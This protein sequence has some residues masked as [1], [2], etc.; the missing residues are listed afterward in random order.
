MLH[1]AAFLRLIIIC[2]RV[3]QSYYEQ[4]LKL[5]SC[6]ST[7]N[8]LCWCFKGDIISSNEFLCLLY[9]RL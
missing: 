9:R 7:E 6:Q 4:Q 2:F 5:Q 8:M 3:A 1:T